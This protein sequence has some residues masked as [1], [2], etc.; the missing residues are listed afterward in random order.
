[1]RT[2]VSRINISI[3]HAIISKGREECIVRWSKGESFEHWA[4]KVAGVI[5]LLRQGFKAKDIEVEKVFSKNKTTC[6]ADIYAEQYEKRKRRQIWLECEPTY[7]KFEEKVNNIRKIFRGKVAFLIN[8]ECWNDLLEY[9]RSS[10]DT[11]YALRKIIPKNTEVWVIHFGEVP[12]V[13]Y[14]MRHQGKRIILLE[15]DW[16]VEYYFRKSEYHKVE[17]LKI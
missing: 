9:A 4:L 13:A 11:H 10:E 14:G 5:E 16:S 12:R 17:K 8:F 15:G 6:R 2:S 7:S 3:S 1:M